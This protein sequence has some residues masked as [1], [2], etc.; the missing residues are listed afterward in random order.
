MADFTHAQAK[1]TLTP[2]CVSAR[3]VMKTGRPLGDSVLLSNNIWRSAGDSMLFL[4]AIVMKGV[5][6]GRGPC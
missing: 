3:V 5:A 6:E 1:N 2:F 4:C